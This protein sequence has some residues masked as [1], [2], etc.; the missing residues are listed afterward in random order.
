M[1]TD[2]QTEAPHEQKERM[3]P[4]Q[5]PSPDNAQDRKSQEQEQPEEQK[6]GDGQ[7]ERKKAPPDPAQR[8]RSYFIAGIVV[9]IFAIGAFA[10]WSHAQ[11]YEDTDDAQIDGHL[12]PLGSRV[13]GTIKAVYVEDNTFVTAGQ[14]LVDLDPSDYEVAL[15]QVRA[16][17]REAA[18]Q[19]T[20][21]RPNV[22]ITVTSNTTDAATA[23][24]EVTNADA[25]VAG[26]EHDYTNAVAQL[27]E[28][29]AN[30]AK[31]Q[32]DLRR[33][34]QLVDKGE[35]AHSE[36]D[37]YE[38]AAKA[39][40]ATV[41][42]QQAKVASAAKTI[43]QRRAQLNEKQLQLKQTVQNAP[44]QL[45][46]RNAN[47]E[48]RQA[49]LESIR[50]QIRQSE[51]NLSYCHIVAPVAGLITQRSAEVGARIGIG[52]QIMVLVQTNNLWVTAN[53]KE[54][55]L[56]RM[57]PGLRVAIKVDALDKTFEGYIDSMP[58]AT[59]DRTSAL[60]P[61]NA[62]GN[63][64]KIVQRLPTRIR[65]KENQDGMRELRPGMSVEPKVY[66]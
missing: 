6:Q 11:T 7:D 29:E 50:A 48:A 38:A 13:T 1:P 4:K 8:R 22:P 5:E 65:F 31:A 33:Y 3:P 40:A 14:S 17:F 61:E 34:K 62:T 12:S 9:L 37:Q 51:L 59:G 26:A 52:Q 57:H 54:T 56:R 46:I 49:N 39:Q 2:F 25:A 18:A 43:D 10:W 64:V 24:A 44:R 60:P 66:L 21:E 19:L 30:N 20:G 47:I 58:A 63:Y 27:Q 36:Y 15:Q 35:V 23:G 41:A 28:A 55:Q 32:S 53:F 45:Q 16:Q 42:A